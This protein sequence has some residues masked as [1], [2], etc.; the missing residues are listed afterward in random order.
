LINHVE[1]GWSWIRD[2]TGGSSRQSQEKAD[3][4]TP[5]GFSSGPSNRATDHTCGDIG[6]PAPKA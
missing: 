2:G 1:S 6:R 5:V 4:V 3:G